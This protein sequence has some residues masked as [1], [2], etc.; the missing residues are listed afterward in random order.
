V[1]IVEGSSFAPQLKPYKPVGRPKPD[2]HWTQDA[3]GIIGVAKA[4]GPLFDS[5]A[6]AI[7]RGAGEDE[8]MAAIAAEE[9]LRRADDPGQK[10][11]PGLTEKQAADPMQRFAQAQLG[12]AQEIPVSAQLATELASQTGVQPGPSSEA[13]AIAMQNAL[14]PMTQGQ[15]QET[16]SIAVSP[17]DVGR[18]G[19]YYGTAQK[20]PQSLVDEQAVT[21]LPGIPRPQDTKAARFYDVAVERANLQRSKQKSAIPD[22][23]SLY[24]MSLDELRNLAQW[25]LS[26]DPTQRLVE[27]KRLNKAASLV[28]KAELGASGF[29]S[30]LGG[31]TGEARGRT[32]VLKGAKT[33]AEFDEMK[34]ARDAQL[35]ESGA[36][37]IESAQYALDQKKKEDDKKANRKGRRPSTNGEAISL[38]ILYDDKYNSRTQNTDIKGKS[39][40]KKAL[41]FAKEKNLKTVGEF[42]DYMAG[43][44]KRQRSLSAASITANRLRQGLEKPPAPPK[45]EKPPKPTYGLT[46]GEQ[47]SLS[48][49]SADL[50]ADF[51]DNGRSPTKIAGL[52]NALNADMTTGNVRA[53]SAAL[54]KLRIELQ[55]RINKLTDSD[56][57]K[58]IKAELR[59]DI[60]KAATV[61]KLL[62]QQLEARKRGATG[63][64]GVP[65]T[66]PRKAPN[67]VPVGR[68][69]GGKLQVA[70]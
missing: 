19:Q 11:V 38:S 29:F 44:R 23:L 57:D 30:A 43:D 65:A 34:A 48:E 16:A 2:R 37:N 50:V 46:P 64:G 28:G 63:K 33:Q 70:R 27:M 32:Y 49:K 39:F 20:L 56:E 7:S 54:R 22:Q 47:A 40:S 9:E 62:Q 12:M 61:G 67:T 1:G 36:L 52:Q 42:L 4:L 24:R 69:D 14:N 59:K 18:V 60:A 3:M 68:A 6:T 53:A 10:I 55:R 58:A 66:G 45:P 5:A 8:L 35:L 13:S 25:G 41:V 51:G 17:T 15:I 31:E 26:S 21:P